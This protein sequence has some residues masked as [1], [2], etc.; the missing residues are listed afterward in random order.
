M[1]QIEEARLR[2]L[3]EAHGRVPTLET[4]RDTAIRER[5]EARATIPALTKARTLVTEANKDLPA[6]AVDRIVAQATVE[7]PLTEAGVLDEEALTKAVET[8]RTAEEAYLAGLAESAGAGVVTGFG[9]PAGGGPA[10]DESAK[11]TTTP[12]G[13]PIKQ[14]A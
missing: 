2:E 13:R 8:A 9:A 4:E 6:A 14:E 10:V 1:P 11:T 12:W 3:E 7:I 5:N